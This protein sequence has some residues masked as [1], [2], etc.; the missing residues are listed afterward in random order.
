VISRHPPA[1]FDFNYLSRS[2]WANV[3]FFETLWLKKL[4]ILTPNFGKNSDNNTDIILND[5]VNTNG[6][7]LENVGTANSVFNIISW[8]GWINKLLSTKKPVQ[9]FVN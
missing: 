2:F 9:V 1:E 3:R 8:L 5:T 7:N 6:N 4:K